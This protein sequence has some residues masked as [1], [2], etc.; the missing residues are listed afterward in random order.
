LDTRILAIDQVHVASRIF[1]GPVLIRCRPEEIERLLHILGPSDDVSLFGEPASLFEHRLRSALLRASA[2]RDRLTGLFRK[3]RFLKEIEDGLETANPEART[4]VIVF[5]IDHLK[6]INA[7]HGHTIGDQLLKD[8]AARLRLRAGSANICARYGG[9]EFGV[10]GPLG[11]DD[12][13]DL[14]HRVLVAARSCPVVGIDPPVSYTVSAGIATAAD[15]APEALMRDALTALYAAKGRGRDRVVAYADLCRDAMESNRDVDVELFEYS[16]RDLTEKVAESIARLGRDL[17]ERLRE[18]ADADGLTRLYSRRYLDKR[19]PFELDQAAR[20][21]RPVTVAL[22]D[23]DSFGLV[24]KVHGWPTGDQV[25]RTV[26][27][28]IRSAVRAADWVARY[29]G[30]E[31]SIVMSDTEM[32]MAAGVLERI[33]AII[34]DEPFATSQGEPL[35][36]TVSIGAATWRGAS[37]TM[38]A[39]FD[40]ASDRLLEAKRTGK[41]RVVLGPTG[42]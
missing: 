5:D 18:Q 39:L 13:L 11:N 10:V 2:D 3:I 42:E 21:G 41:N 1:G 4:T 28:R 26:A 12:A 8:F 34:A 6:R 25:L 15:G 24:N 9:E 16:T 30:E 22:L 19:L 7:E 29:G 17:F 37:E 23:I 40:R 32:E 33:R 20:V 36:V 35:Q 27:D 38:T 14:A 31:I